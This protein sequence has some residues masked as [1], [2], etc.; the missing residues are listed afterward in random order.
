[1]V[2]VLM[3]LGFVVLVQWKRIQALE[4][5]L[6]RLNDRLGDLE[7]RAEHVSRSPLADAG[8]VVRAAPPIVQTRPAATPPPTPTPPAGAAAASPVAPVPTTRRVAPVAAEPSLE[9]RIGGRWLLYVGVITIVIGVAYFEKLAIDNHWI[10]E[11][12]RTIEG[13]LV[14]LALVYG[15]TRFVRRGFTIYGQMISGCGIAVLYVATY[16]AFNMYHLITRPAALLLMMSIT[17]LASWL[18]DRARSQGLA[19]MAVGGGFATPF[20]L[21]SQTDTQI[22][23]FTYDAILIAGTMF[24]AHRRTWPALNVLSYAFTVCTVAIWALAFY[25]SS[26]YLRTELF[27]TLFCAMYGYI[28]RQSRRAGAALDGPQLVLWTAPVL[29]YLASIVILADHSVALLVYLI[30]LALAGATA[31]ARFGPIVRLAGWI[32]VSAPLMVWAADHAS[33]TWLVA[34][35]TAT[36]AVYV[37][38]LLAHLEYTTRAR[39]PLTAA[40]IVLLHANG[41]WAYGTAYLL[42][43]AVSV[44]ATAAVAA[45]LAVGHGMLAFVL[46]KQERE[47][48]LHFA[49]LGFTLL[50]VAIALQFDGPWVIFGWAA[51]G[52]VVTALGVRER[53]EWFRAGGVMLFAIAIARLVALQFAAPP[54]DQIALFNRRAVCGAF[55][56]ALTYWL[57]WLH[58]R[59]Y[60]RPRRTLEHATGIVSAQ[61]LTL[62]LLTSEIVSYWSIN[63]AADSVLARGLM[64]SMTW[65]VYAT[66]L[67]VVGIRKHFAPVRYFAIVLFAATIVKVFMVDLAELDRIY[68][69]SSIVGLGIA[70]LISSYLYQR[71]EREFNQ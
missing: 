51:E 2:L 63:E 19:L 60:E 10:S 6:R 20:L 53:R 59:D 47:H 57:A 28:L 46:A 15:G 52:A 38:H 13:G 17:A 27:L 7:A 11:T 45:V 26:K 14:G 54:I 35:L 49:A 31:A 67:I 22:A 41:L 34:G 71:F 12:A 9:S 62:T 16:A 64:F 43:E 18:A 61:V 8:H 39:R 58:G 4:K 55:T 5:D 48:A 36:T 40:D 25:A 69:I 65:A 33:R 66:I 32:A 24:L 29:Y 70:L 30:A 68:R 50:M 23:L 37:I 1:M 42:I 44:P 56:I 3:V 21:P